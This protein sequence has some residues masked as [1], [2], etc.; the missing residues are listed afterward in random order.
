ERAATARTVVFLADNCGESAL[1][2][3][4]IETLH[5]LNPSA[6]MVYVVRNNVILND[7]TM[8][9]ALAAGMDEV[10]DLMT[11]GDAD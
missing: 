3:I 7:L 4:L 11:N 8:D 1:D 9:E 5:R 2:R 6:R 10:A